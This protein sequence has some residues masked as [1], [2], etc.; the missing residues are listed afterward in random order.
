MRELL[1][2]ETTWKARPDWSADGRR[3]VYSSYHGRQ[4]NQLWLTT[5]DGGDPL[6][7]TFGEYD[8]TAPRWSRDGRRI[9]AVSNEHGNTELVVIDVAGGA[10]HVVQARQRRYLHPRAQLE[11]VVEEGG[12]PVPARVSV[13]AADGRYSPNV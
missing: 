5:A 6:P 9:A 3:V 11:L 1:Y 2:E 10:R 7:L 4:W 12:R 8:L 13:T